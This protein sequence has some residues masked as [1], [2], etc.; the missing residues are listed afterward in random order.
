MTT[1]WGNMRFVLQGLAAGLV[2]LGMALLGTPFA[3]GQTLRVEVGSG[4]FEDARVRRALVLGVD[5]SVVAQQAGQPVQRMRLDYGDET[6]ALGG[7]RIDQAAARRLLA[8]A[9]Y[10]DGAQLGL[11]V[12]HD[13]ASAKPAEMAA[14]YL[15]RLG[16]VPEI[17]PLTGEIKAR[18]DSLLNG[19]VD[20]I[21]ALPPI[22]VMTFDPGGLVPLT[23]LADLSVA[24]LEP[25][26]D[27]VRGLLEIQVEIR[28]TGSGPAP[29]H[30]L[31]VVENNG[32][33]AIPTIPI[34]GIDPGGSTRDAV[35]VEV[36][37]G[38]RGRTLE[39]S[40]EVDPDGRVREV[41]RRNNKTGTVRV[42]IAAPPRPD[43]IAEALDLAVENARRHVIAKVRVRNVG[44]ATAPVSET[45]FVEAARLLGEPVSVRVGP[46]RPGAGTTVSATIPI[47]AGT[48]G[49]TLRMQAFADGP[50]TVEEADE[51]NNASG[52]VS[53]ALVPAPRPKLPD[54]VIDG[55]GVDFEADGRTLTADI[56][57]RNAG[58]APAPGTEVTVRDIAEVLPGFVLRAAVGPLSP[59]QSARIDPQTVVDARFLGQTVRLQ[60][61][62]DAGRAVA[63][64]S[65]RNNFSPVVAQALPVPAPRALPDLVVAKIAGDQ[66]FWS[67][68]LDLKITVRNVGAAASDSS[69]LLVGQSNGPVLATA[70]LPRLQPGESRTVRLRVR[71]DTGLAGGAREIE[72]VADFSARLTEADE[73]N[74][75]RLQTFQIRSPALPWAGIGAGTLGGLLLLGR[76]V[77][78][79]RPSDGSA[80]DPRAVPAGGVILRPR[81]DPG[82]QTLAPGDS[83]PRILF[84]VTL[85]P[86]SDPGVAL[87]VHD[88]PSERADT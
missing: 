1:V 81:P 9:G 23:P 10:L 71:P 52:V 18:L 5:W 13:A 37:E 77:L 27:P 42:A 4:A 25:R 62:A 32:A 31:R 24:A 45:L 74:N 56:Q 2:L 48:Y 66:A 78:R 17:T 38:V 29:A 57:V 67:A 61:E 34:P 76:L 80:Q 68:A 75:A 28:N 44:T 16:F 46:L 40:A 65:E 3:H 82:R 85:R 87:V 41:N 43:L 73:T 84:E 15:K 22:L 50:G 21:R 60:A 79:R 86:V 58:D 51:G 12:I 47:P 20:R 72:A 53:V 70:R 63:E 64:S 55:I 49:R 69:D 59:G 39:L 6:L 33:I 35:R 7:V 88:P 14:A 30:R 36:P 54:L 19:S 11:F 83:P 26:Y 8:E